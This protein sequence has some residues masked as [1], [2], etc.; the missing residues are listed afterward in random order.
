MAV[1]EGRSVASCLA[2]SELEVLGV[3]DRVQLN[4]LE[5]EYQ[6]RQ[7]EQLMRAGVTLADSNRLDVRGTLSCGQDV[8]L[9]V[10]V[11]FEGKVSLGDGVTIGPNCVLRDVTVEAGASHSRH[12]PF[13][14]RICWRWL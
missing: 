10:N 13:A 5:R 14:G 4:Q 8:S 9:D 2:V 1:D 12:E 11:V 3:N 6:R 7:A